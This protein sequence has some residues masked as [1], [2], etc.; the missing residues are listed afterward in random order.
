MCASLL[1][2]LMCYK[3]VEGINIA[4]FYLYL[5]LPPSPLA[6]CAV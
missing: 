6:D 3:A 2:Q 1:N 4:V 5:F